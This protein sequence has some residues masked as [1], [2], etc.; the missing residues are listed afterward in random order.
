MV[1]VARDGRRAFTADIRSGTMTAVD[2]VAGEPR[3]LPVS[4]QTEAIG[5]SPEG[6]QVWV[7][8]NDKGTVT[9]ISPAR[10][11]AID[12]LDL[13]GQPYRI[14][15]SPDGRRVL[16]TTPMSDEVWLFDAATR[17]ELG[18]LKTPSSSGS[19]GQPFG[20]AWS[21]DGT[22]AFVTLRGAAQVAVIDTERMALLR[23]F[24][25][26]PGADGIAFARRP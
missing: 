21:P 3:S 8:S 10:W 6:D 15:F 11:K 24:T 14:V 19:P 26:G 13:G 18:R 17:K 12:T 20:I 23:H 1:V 7:G 5:V 9:V 16:V 22:R 2:L 25:A 4:T